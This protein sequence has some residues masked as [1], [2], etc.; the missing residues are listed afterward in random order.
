VVPGPEQGRKIP[1]YAGAAEFHHAG[2][3]GGVDRVLKRLAPERVVFSALSVRE[4]WL[5]SQLPTEERYLDPLVE[6][7]QMFGTP[8]A[9]VAGFGT[10]LAGWTRDLFPGESP[11]DKRLRVAACALSDIAWRDHVDVRASESFRRLLQFPFIGV[12]H[13]ER[14]FVAATIHARYAG[15][16]DDPCLSPAIS[17]LSANARRRAQILGRAMLLCYRISGGV[18]EILE[19][20]R[21]CIGNEVLRLKIGRAARVPDSE[22]VTSRLQLLAQAVGIKRIEVIETT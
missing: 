1:E 3:G 5:Y 11:A 21:L 22:V 14:V 15:D 2:R 16:A 6:G 4:G 13:R 8:Q 20:A 7:A 18:P 9:R 12:D 17:L 19:G 10:E